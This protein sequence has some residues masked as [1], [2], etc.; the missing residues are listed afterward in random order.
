MLPET[1]K[2]LYDIF[3]A[4]ESLLQFVK[5]K[6]IDDYKA[7]ILLQSGVE[8]QLMIAG[9]ALN[10][11]V[12]AAP[13]LSKTITNI[14]QI[15]NLRNIIVHGYAFIENETIWGIVAEDIP[16]LHEQVRKLLET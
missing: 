5:D 15:V 3:Q 8:R 2:F 10:K 1:R 4:C 9:E 13:E 7:D 11:A 16:S 12:K 6:T 14:R